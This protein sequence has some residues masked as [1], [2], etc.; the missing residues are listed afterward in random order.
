MLP[1]P[2]HPALVHFPIAFAVLLPLAALAALLTIWRGARPTGAWM[3]VV[4][5]SFLLTVSA[6]VALQTGEAQEEVVEEV[7]PDAPLH[8]HEEAGERFLWLSVAGLLVFASGLATGRVGR[9]G[10]GAGLV[11]AMVLLVA[12]VWVGDTG[13]EL[14]YEHGAANAYLDGSVGTASGEKSDDGPTEHREGR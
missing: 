14:V 3:G 9:V 12:G 8:D 13:G 5:L 4:G 10:R 7:V 11:M 1:D 2:L 6:W